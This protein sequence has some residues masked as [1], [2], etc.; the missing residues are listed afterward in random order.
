MPERKLIIEVGID[1]DAVN[2]IED[3][4][5]EILAQDICGQAAMK[6]LD[7]LQDDMAQQVKMRKGSKK[8]HIKTPHFEFDFQAKRALDGMG[9]KRS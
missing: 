7:S 6:Y 2:S 5:R 8:I 3:L 9:K 1:D 4:E